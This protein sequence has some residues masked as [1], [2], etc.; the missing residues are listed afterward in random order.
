MPASST[1]QISVIIPCNHSHTELDRTVAAVCAQ[2]HKPFE[3]VIV[4]S[5]V[6]RGGDIASL[7]NAC[8]N[9]GIQLN[10]LAVDNVF[11]GHARNIGI[12]HAESPWIAL[13]DVSTVPRPCWL[14]QAARQIESDGLDG[15]WGATVFEAF[16]FAEGL[17][18]DGIFGMAPR[19][20][21][22]G[23]VVHRRVMARAGIFIQW[24]RSG[25][26]TDWMLRVKLMQFA[27]ND[28][29]G[30][31]ADYIG[32]R[33]LNSSMMLSKWVHYYSSSR[34]LPHLFNQKLLVW[35]LVYPL[36]IFVALNWNDLVANWRMDSPWYVPNITKAAVIIPPLIYITV[37]GFVIPARRGVPIRKLLPV[38]FVLIAMVCGL[39][40]A[41]KAAMLLFPHTRN[42][43]KKFSTGVRNDR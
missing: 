10:Y 13:I 8:E 39:L 21:L 12:E 9:K 40:D 23:S 41:I 24:V 29:I 25:E 30:V 27:V 14:A 5:S 43:I 11:P 18:R 32:L 42:S 20:T 17:F 16:L 33:G 22:P 15:V 7:V 2:S 36:L 38:R 31:T 26:D 34:S 4:D 37:R 28:S 3:L 35:I 19:Q 1:M 6:D